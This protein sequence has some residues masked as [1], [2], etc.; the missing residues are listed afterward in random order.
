MSQNK[1]LPS[2]TP[3]QRLEILKRELLLGST[4]TEIAE[5]CGVSRKTI[6]RD[7]RKWELTGG[8]EDWIRREFK[9]LFVG[10]SETDEPL[11]FREMSK[12]AA[13]TMTTRTESKVEGFGQLVIWRPGEPEADAEQ[14]EAEGEGERKV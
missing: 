13:R 10:I 3:E 7:I 14:S 11:A 5:M 2:L 12:L 9:D 6:E 8:F 1:E 4:H